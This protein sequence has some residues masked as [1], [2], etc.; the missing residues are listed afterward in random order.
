MSQFGRLSNIGW[1]QRFKINVDVGVG[2]QILVS[3]IADVVN[4]WPL[5]MLE[6]N[7]QI[8]FCCSMVCF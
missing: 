2:S 5:I 7:P 4:V 8:S 6:K 1:V 3:F